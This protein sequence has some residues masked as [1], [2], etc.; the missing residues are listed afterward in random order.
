MSNS[1]RSTCQLITCVQLCSQSQPAECLCLPVLCSST[2]P[3]FNFMLHLQHRVR[4]MAMCFAGRDLDAAFTSLKL[5]ST[6][7]AALSSMA[8]EPSSY[9]TT[10]PGISVATQ[11]SEGYQTQIGLFSAAMCGVHRSNRIESIPICCVAVELADATQTTP[12][13]ALAVWV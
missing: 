2:V 5:L 1:I 3:L 9:N 7:I 4:H 6:R 13:A 10:V 12:S 11:A 8:H